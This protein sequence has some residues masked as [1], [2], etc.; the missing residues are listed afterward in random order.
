MNN[1]KIIARKRKLEICDKIREKY[2]VIFDDDV[3]KKYSELLAY[4]Q[5]FD[6]YAG[7][8]EILEFLN[9]KI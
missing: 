6:Y 3:I 9:N 5:R 4:V 8:L 1:D 7:D 2:N